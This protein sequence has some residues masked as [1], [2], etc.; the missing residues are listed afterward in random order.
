MLVRDMHAGGVER[1]DGMTHRGADE[2]GD[3]DICT[4]WI[5]ILK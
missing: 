4:G 2:R 5:S 1:A 3:T